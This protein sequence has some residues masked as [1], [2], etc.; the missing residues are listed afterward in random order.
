MRRRIAVITTSRSDYGLLYWL[1]AGI[2]RDPSLEL[3]LVATGMHFAPGFGRTVDFIR[4]D[5]FPIAAEVA[6]I[7]RGDSNLATAR[8]LGLGVSRLSP[9][10]ARIDPDLVVVLG[11]RFEM[12]AAACAALCLRLP[13]AH[14]HGG[15]ATFGVIDDRIRHAVTKMALLHFVS[16][17]PYRRRVIQIGRA[18]V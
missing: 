3:A 12:M 11:D 18:H 14:I 6:F 13:L 17:Q 15:E 1:I 2:R 8:S 10:L 7:G 16:A 9:A 4:K 5:G